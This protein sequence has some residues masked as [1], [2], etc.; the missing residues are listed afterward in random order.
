MERS[1][2]LIHSECGLFVW[3]PVGKAATGTA[4]RQRHGGR[5]SLS[6]NTTRTELRPFHFFRHPG[7]AA[8]YFSP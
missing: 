7:P 2:S 6:I 8:L 5:T 3:K 1:F 4:E